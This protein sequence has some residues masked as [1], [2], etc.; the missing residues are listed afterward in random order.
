MIEIKNTDG[1][2]LF[3][4]PAATTIRAAVE[5]AIKAGANLRG[6]DL[7]GAILCG[8]TISDVGGLLAAPGIALEEEK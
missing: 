4:V 2:V 5:E 1:R 3:T 6:A 8:A 7:T